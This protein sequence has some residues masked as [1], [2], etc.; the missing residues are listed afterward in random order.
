MENPTFPT[1]WLAAT[2]WGLSAIGLSAIV[3]GD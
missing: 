1:N 3:T 2:S